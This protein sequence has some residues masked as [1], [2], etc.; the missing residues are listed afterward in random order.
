MK[1]SGRYSGRYVIAQ[2]SSSILL[3][4][5][6]PRPALEHAFRQAAAGVVFGICCALTSLYSSG[7]EMHH[8]VHV[9]VKQTSWKRPFWHLAE[10]LSII[11][12]SY[13]S[14]VFKARDTVYRFHL[15]QS[16]WQLIFM[17]SCQLWKLWAI[18]WQCASLGFQAFL[19]NVSIT[20][21]GQ[22]K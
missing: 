10:F 16:A 5:I 9:S 1:R 11:Y 18:L 19:L 4:G 14:A 17:P 15:T 2:K 13:S 7:T 8:N 20:V 3:S 6:K 12:A 22:Q 21:S